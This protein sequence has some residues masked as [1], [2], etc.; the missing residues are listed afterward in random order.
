[1]NEQEGKEYY[2]SRKSKILTQFDTHARAWRR[3]LAASYGGE[4]AEAVLRDAHEQSA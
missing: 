1:M 3:F 4:F 2:L